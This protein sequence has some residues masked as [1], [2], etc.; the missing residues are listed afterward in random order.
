MGSCM[1]I[2]IGKSRPWEQ[3][4][5]EGGGGAQQGG[6]PLSESVHVASPYWPTGQR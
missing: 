3:K 6:E 5:E 2:L 1:C 4:E